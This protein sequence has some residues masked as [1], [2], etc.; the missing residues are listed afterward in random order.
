MLP[1]IPLAIKGGLAIGS[2]LLASKLGRE[3]NSPLQEQALQNSLLAQ[4]TAMGSGTNLLGMGT[5]AMQTPMNYWQ[6]VAGGNRSAATSAL[7]PE[8]GRIGEGYQT[9]A[10]TS[11]ALNPRGGPSASFM[12]EMPFQQQRDVTSLLQGARQGAM[13]PLAAAGS[14]LLQQGIN[15]ITSATSANRDILASEANRKQIEMERSKSIGTGLYD[16]LQKFG[17]PAIDEML[18]GKGALANRGLLT[19]MPGADAGA[20]S[21]QSISDILGRLRR[22]PQASDPEMPVPFWGG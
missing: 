14:Q 9:A 19:Q 8:I 21:G 15:S 2:S 12:S 5:N 1:L 13:Q 18:K 16:L 11:S 3:K 10:R 17:F 22:L 20:I 7:A 6:S 4:K